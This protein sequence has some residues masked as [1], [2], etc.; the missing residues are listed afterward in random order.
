MIWLVGNRGMLGYDVEF[1]LKRNRLE[2][3][4]TDIDVDITNIE[5]LRHFTLDKQ[6]NY[7]INCAAYTN[8]DGAETDEERTYS[9]N[10]EAVKNLSLIA[11]E[12]DAVLI[13]I[14]TDYVFDG[15]SK[16]AYKEKHAVNPLSVYGRSKLKGEKYIQEFLK[17]YF[18]FRTSWLYGKHGR[19]FVHTMLKLFKARDEIKIISDQYGSPTYTMDLAGIIIEIIKRHNKNYGIYHFTNTGFTNWYEFAK[20]IY[21]IAKKYG[22][23]KKDIKIIPIK[24]EEYPLPAMRPQYSVLSKEK[25]GKEL[26]IFIESWQNSLKKFIQCL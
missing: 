26:N 7:I 21:K 1:L 25:V 10:G 5:V 13:H 16:E 24:T 14:S 20:E 22:I 19:N 2:Y 3:T 15:R 17:N 23:V 12:M 8:V 6:F 18:I 11:K 4:A 9:I